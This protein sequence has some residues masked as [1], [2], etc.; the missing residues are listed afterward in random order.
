MLKYHIS[1]TH[2]LMAFARCAGRLLGT[3]GRFTAAAAPAPAGA[4]IAAAS[5]ELLCHPS[6]A[7]HPEPFVRR[8]AL[9]AAA[10]VRLCL[11][12]CVFL[13]QQQTLSKTKCCNY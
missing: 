1:A 6:V 4:Q 10:Q 5:A 8:S 11:Q 12:Y 13:N 3:V 7:G 9:F 2:L